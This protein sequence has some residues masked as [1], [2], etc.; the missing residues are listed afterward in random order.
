M[1]LWIAV[2]IV[3]PWAF[4]A[5]PLL[6]LS[7]VTGLSVYIKLKNCAEVFAL[8]PHGLQKV[9]QN[10]M[11]QTDPFVSDVNQLEFNL[12]SYSFFFI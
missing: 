2:F 11:L 4:P 1:P 6:G 3:N 8:L 12:F 5:T 7:L 9:S 10:L